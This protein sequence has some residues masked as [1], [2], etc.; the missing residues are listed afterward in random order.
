MSIYTLTA[1]A[2]L[3][4]AGASVLLKIVNQRAGH[5][6]GWL[7]FATIGYVGSALLFYVT[8]FVVFSVIIV[9]LRVIRAYV[10]M[11]IG[12]QILLVLAG[13][14][15]LGESLTLTGVIGMVLLFVGICMVTQ[16]VKGS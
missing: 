12:A 7:E 9:T 5:A 16:G 6:S 14:F 11:T 3:S 15:L 13:V 1:L 8:L 2:I 4:N 10:V